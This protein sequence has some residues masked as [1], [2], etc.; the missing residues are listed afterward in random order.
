MPLA[1]QRRR[2]TGAAVVNFIAGRR[3]GRLRYAAFGAGYFFFFARFF[4]GF[5]AAFF[6]GFFAE[7][8]LSVFG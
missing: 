7:R 5:F 3:S 8:A 4:A 2:R 6:A 1:K